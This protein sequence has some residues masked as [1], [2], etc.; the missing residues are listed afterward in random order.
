MQAPEMPAAIGLLQP[1]LNDETSRVWE[2]FL[3]KYYHDSFSRTMLVGINPGRFG[4][5]VT[6][7]PFTDPI[8]LAD[9]LGIA[10]SF[11]RKQELSSVFVYEVIQAMGGPESF[12][13]H[14]YITSVSPI[15]FVSQGKNINY[16]DDKVLQKRVEPFAAGCMQQQLQWP[17][18]T[19][20]CICMGEGNNFRFLQL[21]N[22]KHKWFTK[23]EA[24][25]H[26]RYIMQYKRKQLDFYVDRYVQLL[27]ANI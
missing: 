22:D 1:L 11:D 9:V 13:R 24:V 18:N 7:I 16:Y 19:N 15:G 5:G 17:I 14:F 27:S 26:P 23:I 3:H 6:G 20:T 10:N 2:L 4:A 8:R 25:P 12:Y 21:L